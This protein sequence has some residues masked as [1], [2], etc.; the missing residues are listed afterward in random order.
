MLAR[1]GLF[2]LPIE[3]YIIFTFFLGMSIAGVL[4]FT[5]FTGEDDGI[6]SLLDSL[7]P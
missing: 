6:M 2:R 7:F 5:T 4:A 1:T 3:A